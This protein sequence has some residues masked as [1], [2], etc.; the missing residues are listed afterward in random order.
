[1]KSIEL[2]VDVSA[3][4]PLPGPLHIA[5]SIFLPDPAKVTAPPIAM[6]GFPGGG[7]S[8]GYFDINVRGHEDYSEAEHHVERGIIFIAADHLGVGDSSIPDLA[9]VS[10]EMLAAA[11]DAAVR[12][13]CSQ[14]AQ[15]SLSPSFPA[16]PNLVRIGIGQSMGGCIT[17]AMQ[18]RLRTYDAIATLG[19]SAIHTVLPQQT[20]AARRQGI[21]TYPLFRNSD[22]RELAVAPAEVGRID[23]LYPFHWE[24]VPKD[25]LDADM[26]GGY[27]IRQTA[28]PWG[29]VTMPVCARLMMTP[30]YVAQEAAAIDVPVLIAA[31]ERDVVPD[32]H[33][34]PGAFESSPD[35]SLY[36]VPGMAH[37]HNFATTRRLLWDRIAAWSLMVAGELAGKSAG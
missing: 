34:E 3:S 37:M 4:V 10:L 14:L 24:D 35:V 33:A 25:I 30:R 29:S 20:Q 1:M 31:G 8:R 18:G 32:P 6:F 15:G 13:I 21:A 2:K 23:F 28:P 7:Y 27:P 19:F 36:V 16:Q 9:A 12:M 22:L 5:A 17:I 26:K 11:N